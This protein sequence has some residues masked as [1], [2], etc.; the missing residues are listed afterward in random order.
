VERG[1][2]I[3]SGRSTEI[4]TT[5]EFTVVAS[6]TEADDPLV[7]RIDAFFD[8]EEALAHSRAG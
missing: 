7:S 2:W 3:G 1:R 8:H 6:F 5:L 4:T